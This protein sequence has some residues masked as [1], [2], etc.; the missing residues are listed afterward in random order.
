MPAGSLRSTASAGSIT[1]A[2][3]VKRSSTISQPTATWPS[4]V[5]RRSCA[6]SMRISTTVLATASAMPNTIP[7]AWLQPNAR[8]IPQ[9]ATAATALCATA[10]GTAM[11]QTRISSCG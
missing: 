3:T 5:L 6:T 7:A 10:P 1:S 4:R 8:A 11:R 2:T 9:P